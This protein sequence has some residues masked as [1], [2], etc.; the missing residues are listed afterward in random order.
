MPSSLA[1][2]IRAASR[3]QDAGEESVHDQKCQSRFVP[4]L[5]DCGGLGIGR[6]PR[7]HWMLSRSKLFCGPFGNARFHLVVGDKPACIDVNLRLANRGKKRDFVRNIAIVN[8]VGKTVDCL[9]DLLLDAHFQRVAENVQ[10]DK[11]PSGPVL[12]TMKIW[13]SARAR[14]RLYF[15]PKKKGR[16]A[17]PAVFV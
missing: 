15:P 3:L 10:P 9:K 11:R 2:L 13:L 4:L 1:K 12:D 5:P 16:V 8:V 6:L 17:G 14:G 7:C